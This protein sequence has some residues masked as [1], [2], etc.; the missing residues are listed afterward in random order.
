MD[1]AHPFKALSVLILA[2]MAAVLTLLLVASPASAHSD[3]PTQTTVTEGDGADGVDIEDDATEDDATEDPED[4]ETEG[5]GVEGEGV[6]E[7]EGTDSELGIVPAETIPPAADDS[8]EQPWT[9]RFL[10]PT[11]LI[12][13]VL[14][15]IGSVAYYGM[16]VKSRYRVVD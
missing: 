12:L 5:E 6:D 2:A 15:L 7:G 11:I 1:D 10:A 4:E 13:G 3:E 14:G 9:Q 8:F 16:R